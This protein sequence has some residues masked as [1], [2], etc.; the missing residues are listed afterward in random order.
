MT[1]REQIEKLVAKGKSGEEVGRALDIDSGSAR[2][3]MRQIKSDSGAKKTTVSHI[4][5][6]DCQIRPGRVY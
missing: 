1:R 4:M 5:V 3:I 2:R 6:P